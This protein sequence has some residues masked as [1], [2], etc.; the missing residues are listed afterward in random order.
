MEVIILVW[1]GLLSIIILYSASI[2]I[3]LFS[4][5]NRGLKQTIYDVLEGQTKTNKEIVEI[6]KAIAQHVK[7]A[8]HHFYKTAL[9]RFNPFERLGGQQS[10][11]LAILNE[12]N[13]GLVLT[14]LYTKEGVRTYVKEVF[15]GKGGEVELSKE[16]KQAI[17]LADQN[18]QNKIKN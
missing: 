12:K 15:L 11:S 9:V 1:L 16:E 6:K 2:I 10:Y 18:N 13:S 3:K 4:A 5:K 14:F 17:L 8:Q 7:E